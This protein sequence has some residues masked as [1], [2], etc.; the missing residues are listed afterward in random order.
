MAYVGAYSL[1]QSHNLQLESVI[2]EEIRSEQIYTCT[3]VILVWTVLSNS[4]GVSYVFSLVGPL[5]VVWLSQ[6]VTLRLV[7]VCSASRDLSSAAA[8]HP[9]KSAASN[10]IASSFATIVEG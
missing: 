10:E 2:F 7:V 1:L 4:D 3:V 5:A 6:A 9:R 8:A